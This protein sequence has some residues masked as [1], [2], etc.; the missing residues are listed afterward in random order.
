M[1]CPGCRVAAGHHEYVL[2]HLEHCALG[3]GEDV[4]EKSERTNMKEPFNGKFTK[5]EEQSWRW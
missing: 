2:D 5:Q 4:V 1:V 3:V